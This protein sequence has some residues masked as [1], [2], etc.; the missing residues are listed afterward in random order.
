MGRSY[1]LAYMQ[2]HYWFLH[3]TEAVNGAFNKVFGA[4]LYGC[5]DEGAFGR[6]LHTLIRRYEA[7]RTVFRFTDEG[8]V[9]YILDGEKIYPI[10][11]NI[12]VSEK[13]DAGEVLVRFLQY[14]Q[15]YVHDL[16]YPPFRCR[17]VR[18]A[19]SHYAA[20][21]NWSY[22]VGDDVSG[23]L[24]LRRLAE[25]Y[26]HEINGSGVVPPP[27]AQPKD[28]VAA[29]QEASFQRRRTIEE[30]YWSGCL[31]EPLT[32]LRFPF[33]RA[34]GDRPSLR[35]GRLELMLDPASSLELEDL[36]RARGSDLKTL[37]LAMYSIFL[38]KLCDVEDVAVVMPT[39][40]RR[41]DGEA[42]IGQLANFMLVRSRPEAQL[43]FPVFLSEMQKT[44]ADAL[45][46]Q[47]Y[48][49]PELMQRVMPDVAGGKGQLLNAYFSFEDELP[50][51]TSM[52]GIK[53]IPLDVAAGKTLYD[54]ACTCS[55]T[56]AGIKISLVYPSER[57]SGRCAGKLAMYLEN[58][59]REILSDDE[60]RIS[61]IHVLGREERDR[62]LHACNP[63]EG[64]R[65]PEGTVASLFESHVRH[66]PLAT[67]V[68][69]AGVEWTYEELDIRAERIAGYLQARYQVRAGVTAATFCTTS[70]GAVAGLLGIL[71][72]GGIL[73]AID[74]SLAREVVEYILEDSGAVVLLVDGDLHEHLACAADIVCIGSIDSAGDRPVETPEEDSD[75]CCLLYE[76]NVADGVRGVIQ[77][78]ANIL[79]LLQSV[80]ELVPADKREDISWPFVP[81]A[82]NYILKWL[83]P[84]C[85]GAGIV[86]QAPELIAGT[87]ELSLF[88]FANYHTDKDNNH[89]YKQ[90]LDAVRYADRHGFSGVW[91]PERHFHQFGGLFPN[92]SILSAALAMVTSRIELRSGSIVSPLH[93]A[94]R[95][96]EEWA[97]VDNLSGGR[98]SLSFAPGWNINDFVLS[99]GNYEHRHRIMH[100]QIETVRKLWRGERILRQNGQGKVVQIFTF[101]SPLQKELPI[102]LTAAGNE[103][104]FVAAGEKGAYLLTHLLGQ[105]M[106]ELAEKIRLYR[107]TRKRSGY[108]EASGKV[109]IMLHAY[110]GDDI[111][112]VE[113]LVEGPFIEYLKSAVGLSSILY[114]EAGLKEEEIPPEDR[115]T[116][117][118]YS[119]K[120]YYRNASL[121]GT[122]ESCREMVRKLQAIGVNDIACLVDFGIA[123]DKV[124]EGLKKL[125]LLKDEFATGQVGRDIRRQQPLYSY[126][127]PESALVNYLYGYEKL[128]PHSALYILTKDLQFAPEGV[129]GDVYIG[130]TGISPGYWQN[131]AAT[132]MYF[133]P[134]PFVKGERLFRTGDRGRW[135]PNGEFVVVPASSG[136]AKPPKGYL[137]PP[138]TELEEQLTII[139]AGL[140]GMNAADISVDKTLFE[141]GGGVV[142]A[143][144]LMLSIRESMGITV[145]LDQVFNRCSVKQLAALLVNKGAKDAS[146]IPASA[147]SAY[148]PTSP[149]QEKIYNQRRS[150]DRVRRHVVICLGDWPGKVDPVRL[151]RA[152]RTLIKIQDVLRTGFIKIGN[153]LFQYVRD[154]ADVALPELQ[155]YDA[156][157]AAVRAMEK[158]FDDAVPG[159]IRVGWVEQEQGGNIVLVAADTLVC[160]EDSICM[161]LNELRDVY[162]GRILPPLP[163]RYV[164][165]AVWQDGRTGS[166]EEQTAFWM[167]QRAW[168]WPELALPTITVSHPTDMRPME[169]MSF[170]PDQAMARKI[171]ELAQSA[172][173][174]PFCIFLSC[175]Y[176]LLSGVTLEDHIIIDVE[177]DGRIQ[178]KLKKVAGVFR[179]TLPIGMVVGQ[180]ACFRSFLQSL[181]RFI[182]EAAVNQ[183]M[184]YDGIL[185]AM[186]KSERCQAFFTCHDLTDIT[187]L[188]GRGMPVE[189]YQLGMV[190]S[191]REGSHHIELLFERQLF[192]SDT[193]R[194]FRGY[195]LDV[196]TAV[197]EDPL[198]TIESIEF[199]HSLGKV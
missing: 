160:D 45:Q 71:K 139:Y 87:M 38:G 43:E 32:A 183:R 128:L 116:M 36:A 72:C 158:P 29:Q 104:T 114:R 192:D 156:T 69:A 171:A 40:D 103:K 11:E 145:W 170:A 187:G 96:A 57:C 144:R 16:H 137:R 64:L 20:L 197:L 102:W 111:R 169:S 161:L 133:I 181:S 31:E 14:E 37:L 93:D 100:E 98:V 8:P 25:S 105:D 157:E 15:E 21:F 91:V 164:D 95:I 106:D 35:A 7:L 182:P 6:A 44:M 138:G 70:P 150:A 77:T 176:I 108:S 46:F 179:D 140:T 142:E 141:L 75:I 56:A 68:V 129:E 123:G 66:H 12:D 1:G 152:L 76:G 48:P 9:Q 74:P 58:I 26:E 19:D 115:E 130:G 148:Y 168:Q 167:K 52:A 121:I 28:Q 90:L 134:N 94:I 178:R 177:I 53:M 162:E 67:A 101:P 175:F 79:H 188:I 65:L 147:H 184:S 132:R 155:K 5:L 131:P 89:K 82:G 3:H 41:A 107:A 4:Y 61:C 34:S 125:R 117:L 149:V 193:I 190:V 62:I 146:L 136:I 84:L 78:N 159:L 10:I 81:A 163:L 47:N 83:W 186:G 18:L 126:G 185:A 113:Q 189:R 151:E 55:G 99:S 92:P 85:Y 109:A 97:V 127:R 124:M 60:Q 88:F 63:R 23:I 180:D 165:Y 194:Q 42:M 27:G 119:F 153:R 22:L 39:P 54:L 30:A 49:Y 112:Q 166:S 196:L 143:A 110:I 199:I 118:R 173:T 122:L 195:Y 120:R 135:M 50:A 172:R 2:R 154:A 174:S 59:C 191:Q 24:F 13:D 86:M 73:V 51:E 33:D 80:N 198:K 17:L